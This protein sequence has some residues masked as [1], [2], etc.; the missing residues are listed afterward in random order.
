M[1]NVSLVEFSSIDRDIGIACTST[2][3][4]GEV[5]TWLYPNGDVVLTD[6]SL[7]VFVVKRTISPLKRIVLYKNE[8][9]LSEEGIYTCMVAASDDSGSFFTLYVG[10]FN[11]IAGGESLLLVLFVG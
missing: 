9:Q 8:N 3:N 5:G 6:Q 7:A 11:S 4:S 10:I 1:L 2:V